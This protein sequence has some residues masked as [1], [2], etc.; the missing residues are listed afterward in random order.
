MS[1]FKDLSILYVE[2]DPQ[3]RL[4]MEILL[5]ESL[6]VSRLKIFENSANFE[7]HLDELPF[8]PNIIFLDIHMLPIDG[9]AM[10]QILRSHPEYQHTPILALTAS[11]MN[12]EVEQ[13]RSAGFNGVI[14]KP[15]NLDT[16]PE[17]LMQI[18]AGSEV[19]RVI[20]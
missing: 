2:D 6:G 13:L 3:S 5:V 7:V 8:Q 12:E 14:P 11:V 4:V 18:I 19:W 10:L 20:H 17:A 9:F 15:I 1:H 16:F